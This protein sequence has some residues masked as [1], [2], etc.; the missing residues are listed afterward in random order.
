VIDEFEPVDRVR[1]TTHSTGHVPT[2]ENRPAT[3]HQEQSTRLHL[4]ARR[5]TTCT[6]QSERISSIRE[7]ISSSALIS[8]FFRTYKKKLINAERVNGLFSPGK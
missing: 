5:R 7:R 3:I 6:V 8:F 1:G 2:Q 4:A